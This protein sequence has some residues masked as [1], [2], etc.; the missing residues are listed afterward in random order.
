MKKILK[1]IFIL[2]IFAVGVLLIY[3]LV[4]PKNSITSLL[5]NSK[6]NSILKVYDDIVIKQNIK[7]PMSSIK[8]ID[9]FLDSNN[10]NTD[11]I[12]YVDI[13]SK[14][15]K[16]FSEK[17]NT[18]NLEN[19]I[20]NIILKKEIICNQNSKLQF[21][22][23]CPSCTEENSL[24]LI[25]SD[26]FDNNN[27]YINSRNKEQAL[28]MELIGYRYNYNFS[29][30]LCIIFLLLVSFYIIFFNSKKI[31]V[32]KR[33]FVFEFT[34][35]SISFI[36]LYFNLI[37]Y[38]YGYKI[39]LFFAMINIILLMFLIILI[40]LLIKNNIGKYSNLYLTLVIPLI[41]IY[42]IFVIPNY[43]PDE[44][45]HFYHLNDLISH[46]ILSNNPNVNIPNDLL[47][48]NLDTVNNYENLNSV[49]FKSTNYNK[50]SP[51]ITSAKGYSYILY[52][53]SGIGAIIGKVFS[54]PIMLNYYLSRLIN[55]IAM[56]IIGYYI[57]KIIPF[58]KNIVLIYLLN[59]MYLHE[60]CSVSADAFVNSLCLLFIA[61]ILY[62]KNKKELNK[63]DIFII[64]LLVL[65][66]GFA[67]YVYIPLIFLIYLIVKKFNVTNK[68]YKKYLIISSLLSIII[69]LFFF[70]KIY[71]MPTIHVDINTSTSNIGIIGQ[72]KYII[73]NP[74]Y[75]FKT[76]TSTFNIMGP[77]YIKTF[78]GKYLGWLN[79]SL[80]QYITWIYA[81]LLISSPFIY[82]GKETG[83]LNKREKNI[84]LAMTALL[85]IIVI[86]SMW[87]SWTEIG[88][89]PI[90]GVQGRYFIPFMIMLFLALSSKIK[91]IKFKN[92]DIVVSILIII[93]NL[94]VLSTFISFFE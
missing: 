74:V 20:I 48:Y 9:L 55:C 1:K 40:I 92:Y 60:M 57:I 70:I 64:S 87:L 4:Y 67:K 94:S 73:H 14:G 30:F 62:C 38:L 26:R 37:D 68:K 24:D 71:V 50:E 34:I 35:S 12:I 90:S 88:T 85:S 32:K 78:F 18:Q 36:I 82:C 6:N 7:S 44:P 93:I 84:F 75:A 43:V 76:I 79:I 39:N 21:T 53:F 63:R 42:S 29:I 69:C 72:I 51:Y 11:E 61:S 77:E 3:S 89:Y 66:L 27:L 2:L 23:S 81:I 47:K 56:M 45:A 8:R 13:Y 10:N 31:I 28:K 19:G 86:L 80:N 5:K 41:F 58:G 54:L 17:Y 91:K 15:K 49:L 59:P 22:I 52:F 16:V 33:H 65:L 46:N 83:Y 25:V